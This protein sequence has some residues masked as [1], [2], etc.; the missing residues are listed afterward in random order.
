MNEKTENMNYILCGRYKMRETSE[1][2]EANSINGQ[3][4]GEETHK[5]KNMS[6]NGCLLCCTYVYIWCADDVATEFV[7]PF[8]MCFFAYE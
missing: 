4:R 3:C 1:M 6:Y 7:R 8:A 5:M 2:T